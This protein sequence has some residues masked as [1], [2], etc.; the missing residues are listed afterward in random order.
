M[1]YF[2]ILTVVLFSCKHGDYVKVMDNRSTLNFH[3]DTGK[4]K[5][6]FWMDSLHVVRFPDDIFLDTLQIEINGDR[7]VIRRCK[8]SSLDVI[9]VDSGDRIISFKGA[10]WRPRI[11]L[12]SVIDAS[13][14]HGEFHFHDNRKVFDQDSGKGY[15]RRKY[16]NSIRKKYIGGIYVYDETGNLRI[17]S[18]SSLIELREIIDSIY[19]AAN[20]KHIIQDDSY[21][22][23]DPPSLD[24]LQKI[25][26]KYCRQILIK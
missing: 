16:Q 10:L 21:H 15:I 23:A 13:K 24:S 1:K 26:T 11:P 4:P 14:V 25:W 9:S 17:D 18:F 12:D 2:L 3:Y 8:D 19:N 22:Y 5:Y 6:Y 7:L 20:K